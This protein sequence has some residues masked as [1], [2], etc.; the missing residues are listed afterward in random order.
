M[1]S[2]LAAPCATPPPALPQEW[3]DSTAAWPRASAP[4]APPQK[5]NPALSIRAAMVKR[6]SPGS[7][8]AKRCIPTCR[9]NSREITSPVD[10]SFGSP[11]GARRGSLLAPVA[12][13]I[14]LVRRGRGGRTGSRHRRSILTNGHTSPAVFAEKVR[15]ESNP[16]DG[17][18]TGIRTP[19]TAVKGRCPRPLDDGVVLR[20][21]NISKQSPP[22]PAFL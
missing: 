6:F 13:A 18:P 14:A 22:W 8:S 15:D 16:E 10:T 5:T 9:G 21:Q 11:E 12:S 7:G 20:R 3:P 19:V 1:A 17:D 2:P 4:P